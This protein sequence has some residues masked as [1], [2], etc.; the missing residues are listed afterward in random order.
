MR[1]RIAYASKSSL[2]VFLNLMFYQYKSYYYDSYCLNSNIINLPYPDYRDSI[3][4]PIDQKS[5]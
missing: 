1:L 5:Y 4:V 3:L 2:M